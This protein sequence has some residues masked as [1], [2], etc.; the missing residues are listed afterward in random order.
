MAVSALIFKVNQLGDNVIFLPVVQRLAAG[1]IFEKLAV[2]TTPTA[3]PLFRKL[4]VELVVTT[5]ADFYPAWKKPLRLLGLTAEIRKFAPDFVLVAEDMGNT[6]YFLALVSGSRRRVGTRPPYLRI[7]Q[8]INEPLT[9]ATGLPEAEK[10]W[11]L[12][13]ALAESAGQPA[14][15]D[16][17]PP[18]DVSHLSRREVPPLDIFI[19]AGASQAYKRWP[20]ARYQELATR[21]AGDF[22]V[23]WCVVPEAP[24]PDAPSVNRIVPRDLDDLVS[25]IAC[26]ALFVGNN[27]GPMNVASALGIP[28]LLFIGSSARSW[29]PYWHAERCRILRHEALPCIACGPPRER[30]ACINEQTPMACMTYWSVDRAEQ[31]ARSW[32]EKWAPVRESSPPAP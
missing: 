25:Q 26:S 3:A 23:G 2:W 5:R 11:R 15:T 12:G 22:R 24:A 13:S 16:R 27:S 10:S 14:W 1:G 4:P 19:H 9:L 21:L 6:A 31:E 29:D 32:L 28:S 18:P 8:A 17:P 30:D 7:P 20:L